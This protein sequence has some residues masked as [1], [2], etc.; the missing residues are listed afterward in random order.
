VP[1]GMSQC[2]GRAHTLPASYPMPTSFWHCLAWASSI[3]PSTVPLPPLSHWPHSL[4][5]SFPSPSPPF[6]PLPSFLFPSP[7]LPPFP[8]PPLPFLF[9]RW[10]R[11]PAS[12]AASRASC[13]GAAPGSGRGAAGRARGSMALS[14][15]PPRDLPSQPPPSATC[16]GWVLNWHACTAV[17]RSVVSA[18]S[19]CS[20]AEVACSAQ[21][22]CQYACTFC[23]LYTSPPLPHG[24]SLYA[25]PLYP[26]FCHYMQHRLS[27]RVPE[28][29]HHGP[30]NALL[31]ARHQSEA[32]PKV[33]TVIVL[34]LLYCY[35]CT[36]I[37][38]AP[39]EGAA[40]AAF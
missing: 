21:V 40:L 29:G 38:V 6:L 11:S 30:C 34:L 31:S 23:H 25:A 17:L 16:S 12:P 1:H 39:E 4:A 27:S 22:W 35:S 3:V 28:V 8:S 26:A 19:E 18:C 24:L 15:A 33:P 7:P 20:S 37:V 13:R 36:L 14:R 32:N 2:V 5:L 10:Q 9:L